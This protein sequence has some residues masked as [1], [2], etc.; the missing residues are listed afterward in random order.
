MS[1]TL[2]QIAERMNVSSRA[3]SYALNGQPGV[4]D[5]TRE[6]IRKA[7]QEMGYRPSA[8]ARSMRSSKTGH[9]GVLIRNDDADRLTHLMAFETILGINQGLEDAGYVLS[10]VRIGDIRKGLVSDS[11]VFKEHLLDGLIVF[12]EMPDK[13]DRKVAKLIPNVIY[14]ES[15]T[16]QDEYCLRRDERHA[17]RLCAEHMIRLGYRDLVWVS[18]PGLAL[19]ANRPGYSGLDRERGVRDVAREAGVAVREFQCAYDGPETF[20]TTPDFL[21]SLTPNTAV[22]AGQAYQARWFQHAAASL[23]MNPPQDFGVCCCDD[24]YDVSNMWPGL[25]RVSFD[26]YGLGLVAADMM[27]SRLEHPSADCPSRTI[28]GRWIPGNTAWGPAAGRIFSAS[29]AAARVGGGSSDSDS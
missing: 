29:L 7:A 5:A 20:A 25:S 18:H 11:R 19:E 10:L 24:G 9:V 3:V 26:R 13:L 6:R 12:C 17:G 23:G 1:V 28:K 2:S 8:A 14:A 27:R 21:A 4:S 15:Q 22:I 16:W